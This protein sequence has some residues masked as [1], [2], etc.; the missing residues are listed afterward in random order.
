MG[1]LFWTLMIKNNESRIIIFVDDKSIRTIIYNKIIK[2]FQK[3]VE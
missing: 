1:D 2:E 3:L